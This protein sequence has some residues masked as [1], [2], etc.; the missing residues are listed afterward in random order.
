MNKAFIEEVKH[1]AYLDMLPVRLKEKVI[2]V[3]SSLLMVRQMLG[4]AG[5]IFDG[6]DFDD[7]EGGLLSKIQACQE[8]EESIELLKIGL[9]DWAAE[10][11]QNDW[12]YSSSCSDEAIKLGNKMGLIDEWCGP[13]RAAKMLKQLEPQ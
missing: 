2:E 12:V 13:C 1:N 11:C 10:G 8:A 7:I 6:G 4:Q 9:T 5:V 3:C